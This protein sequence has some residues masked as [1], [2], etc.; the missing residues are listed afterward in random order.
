MAIPNVDGMSV[1]QATHT[2]EKAG[3]SVQVNQ[4]GPVDTVFNYSPNTPRTRTYTDRHIPGRCQNRACGW[5]LVEEADRLFEK[6][7]NSAAVI[8]QIGRGPSVQ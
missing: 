7:F 3:F 1:D 5:I 6:G 2:L 8:L 4:V